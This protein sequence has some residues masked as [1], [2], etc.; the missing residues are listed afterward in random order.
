MPYKI[1]YK[2]KKY[3]LV[4]VVSKK[5]IT[6]VEYESLMSYDVK[7]EI[8]GDF[9]KIKAHNM[10]QTKFDVFKNNKDIGDIDSNWKGEI[11]LRLKNNDDLTKHFQFKLESVWKFIY[12]IHDYLT[13]HLYRLEP[14][15]NWKK[16]RYDF[17]IT[18][19][20]HKNEHEND[21]DE[22]VLIVMGFYALNLYMKNSSAG[23]T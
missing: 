13:N 21:V 4:D 1:E 7:F 16:F 20:E 12:S 22:Q 23:S 3:E 8:D 15:Y 10:W 11:I 14:V 5:V 19:G 17:Y 18:E 9:Y 2:N 6:E